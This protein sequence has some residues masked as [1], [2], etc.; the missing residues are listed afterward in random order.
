M[1]E[2]HLYLTCILSQYD[3]SSFC[4]LLDAFEH[5]FNHGCHAADEFTQMEEELQHMQNHYSLCMHVFTI[6]VHSSS[7]VTIQ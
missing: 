3:Y 2:L 7:W 4:T 6:S 5:A 1:S